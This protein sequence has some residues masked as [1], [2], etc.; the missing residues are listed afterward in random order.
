MTMGVRC[1]WDSSL[2]FRMTTPLCHPEG[3]QLEGSHGIR[4]INYHCC[5][6]DSS[7]PAGRQG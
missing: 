4:K 7:L 2:T 3:L 6:G 5:A 1:A